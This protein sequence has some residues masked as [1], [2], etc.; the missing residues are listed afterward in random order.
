MTCS[1]SS[2]FRNYL[3]HLSLKA[4]VW[5]ALAASPTLL[6]SSRALAWGAQGH[7]VVNS[8]AAD[9][10]TGPAS[11][12]F[13]RHKTALARLANTPDRQWKKP[14]TYKDE[15]PTH[16]FHWDHYRNTE[17]AQDFDSYLLSE[18]LQQ[19]GDDYINKNGSAIW[20]V[21]GLFQKL[22]QA[23][24]VKDWNRTLQLAG[25]MGH[26]IADISQPMHVSSDYDGQSIGRRGVHKYFETTLVQEVSRNRLLTDTQE[27]GW[28]QRS[29]LD[30]LPRQGAVSRHARTLALHESMLSLD[31][32][33]GVLDQ[34]EPN[35]Q[36]DAALKEYFGPRMGAGAATLAVLYDLAF[37]EADVN[38]GFP[39]GTLTVDEPEFIPVSDQ[40]SNN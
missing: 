10:M 38:S 11:G 8:A 4:P 34:F 20:R 12:F 40:L 3:N 25:V 14:G 18:A 15:A 9:L 37:E 6:A 27:H 21:S 30:N 19:L 7:E 35:D 26:Y 31:E 36:D 2:S 1:R 22:V 39:T 28:G 16:F 5:L 13:K 17:L 33:S 29:D 23:I 24:K 32:L